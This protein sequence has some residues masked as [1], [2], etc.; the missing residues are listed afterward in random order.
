MSDTNLVDEIL[1]FEVEEHENGKRLDAM[2]AGKDGRFSRSRFKS[3]IKEGK[4]RLAQPD[5]PERTIEE[6]NHRVN[7]G[8]HITVTLPPPEDPTP[9]GEDIPLDVVFED[10]DLIVIN[11]PTGLVVHPAAGNWTGTLVNALIYHCGD[12]LSGIGGVRRPGIVHRLDK[13]T[14]GLLVVAKSDAAHKGLSEQFADHGRTGPLVRAYQALVWGQL[15][16][17]KGTIDTQIGRAQ[18]NRLKQKVL[19][20]GGRQA[21][22]HYQLMEEFGSGEDIVASRVECRLET[23]RTHQIRVHMAHIG[24]PLIG[25]QDYGQGFKSK[26][27]KLPETLARHVEKRK[28]QALHAGLLGFAHPITGGVMEFQSEMPEDL[29]NVMKALQKM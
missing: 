22:T 6:P 9:H 29:K 28:R 26:I 11:K 20:E 16:S 10:D 21:I 27:N 3:L 17:K 2:I 25:D 7:A 5:Q 13:E 19:R 14:S 18:H 4:V 12:S 1:T 24:H 15:R 8:E 23:G